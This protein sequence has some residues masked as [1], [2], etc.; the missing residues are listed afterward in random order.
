MLLF[1]MVLSKLWPTLAASVSAIRS[2]AWGW[3]WAPRTSPSSTVARS[4]S[5]CGRMKLPWRT[6]SEYHC[7]ANI[8][9]DSIFSQ[10]ILLHTA[11]S[12]TANVCQYD[13]E[14]SEELQ[15]DGGAEAFREVSCCETH[16][17]LEETRRS[18]GLSWFL[19]A[20][21]PSHVLLCSRPSR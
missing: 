6:A 7:L 10:V 8:I 12:N 9:I 3:R 15:P 14:P 16:K 4:W 13:L 2:W 21:E 5:F 1:Q 18:S 20:G 11:V 17:G 19:H